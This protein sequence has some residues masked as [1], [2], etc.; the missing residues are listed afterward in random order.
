MCGK[1]GLSPSHTCIWLS[2]CRVPLRLLPDAQLADADLTLSGIRF[3]FRPFPH[4]I[5]EKLFLW[6]FALVHE[7]QIQSWLSD[8]WYDGV[9]GQLVVQSSNAAFQ[10][11]FNRSI[12]FGGSII[13][14]C[15]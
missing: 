5:P 15:F 10:Q 12:Y 13:L 4:I 1:C 6:G 3:M 9:R 2:T 14:I 7:Y 11:Y 8:S